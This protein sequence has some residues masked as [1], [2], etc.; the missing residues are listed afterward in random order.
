MPG[1]PTGHK[2]R[3]PPWY[4]KSLCEC[5]QGRQI[6]K[7][8]YVNKHPFKMKLKPFSHYVIYEQGKNE[9][10]KAI[11]DCI[12]RHLHMYAY[13]HITRRKGMLKNISDNSMHLPFQK[14]TLHLWILQ[15]SSLVLFCSL[16]LSEKMRKLGHSLDELSWGLVP[17]LCSA[18]LFQE[19]FRWFCHLE[20]DV[21]GKTTKLQVRTGKDL[22]FYW[23][24]TCS[25]K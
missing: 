25:L 14:Q 17:G 24:C 22:N 12:S 18:S 10:H 11:S 3:H 13:I 15:S 9:R 19:H 16:L 1:F 5:S 2:F 8:M 23:L 7:D 4:G 20:T 6:Q 21:Y